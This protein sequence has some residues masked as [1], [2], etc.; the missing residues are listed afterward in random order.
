MSNFIYNTLL[1]KSTGTETWLPHLNL[2]LKMIL[3]L[4]KY[5]DIELFE[6][7]YKTNDPTNGFSANCQNWTSGILQIFVPW[8]LMN[9]Y[10]GVTFDLVFVLT[11]VSILKLTIDLNS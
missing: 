3:L 11:K 8:I 2:S 10:R 6:H 7:L 4:V 5:H 9:F 1:A